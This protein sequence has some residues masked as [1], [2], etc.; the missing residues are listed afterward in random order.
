MKICR[1]F[2]DKLKICIC[3]HGIIPVEF[4]D[5]TRFPECINPSGFLKPEDLIFTGVIILKKLR[6]CRRL[7]IIY[8]FRLFTDFQ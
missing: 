4:S 1:T 7:S 3:I 5:K 2:F 6:I 8:I